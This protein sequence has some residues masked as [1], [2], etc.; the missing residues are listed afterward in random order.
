MSPRVMPRETSAE[1]R[2]RHRRCVWD[3][4]KTVSWYTTEGQSPKTVAARSR[5]PSG[6]S[7]HEFAGLA[8]S[9]SIAAG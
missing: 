1:A 9:L 4:V 3:Q 8:P 7:G 6:V 2:R 5:K